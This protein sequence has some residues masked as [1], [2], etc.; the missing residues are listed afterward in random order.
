MQHR[1]LTS[2]GTIAGNCNEFAPLNP[3]RRP[4]FGLAHNFLSGT[5]GG[6][7]ED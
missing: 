4:S 7:A 3:S 5:P 1:Y 2:L 6:V